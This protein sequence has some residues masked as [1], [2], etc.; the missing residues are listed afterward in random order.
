MLIE[1][2]KFMYSG[3]KQK[4]ASNAIQNECIFKL[5]LPGL[6]EAYNQIW[7]LVWS[8]N[9]YANLLASSFL[10]FKLLRNDHAFYDHEQVHSLITIYSEILGHKLHIQPEF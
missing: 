4:L 10:M 6:Y 9:H 2:A 8:E 5:A 1:T 3:R 7:H